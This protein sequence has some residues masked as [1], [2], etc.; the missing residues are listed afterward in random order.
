MKNIEVEWYS[1]RELYTHPKRVKV[2]GVWEEVFSYEKSI[3]EHR[4]TKKR[5]VVFRCHIGD[6]RTIEIT[7]P[8][9]LNP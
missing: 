8:H 4:V 1:G 2:D 6:N 7:I 3:R 9:T 5:E